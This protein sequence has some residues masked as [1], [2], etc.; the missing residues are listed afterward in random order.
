MMLNAAASRD[1]AVFP[2]R[3]SSDAYGDWLR[4]RAG[5]RAESPSDSLHRATRYGIAARLSLAQAIAK[6]DR[7]SLV[8]KARNVVL[9]GQLLSI[10]AP[11]EVICGFVASF[12]D[13]SIL[14][15]LGRDVRGKQ[16]QSRVLCEAG[17]S[18]SGPCAGDRACF[19][20]SR[21]MF[22]QSFHLLMIDGSNY[23]ETNA[24]D[25]PRHP[26]QVGRR[27]RAASPALNVRQRRDK[28]AHEECSKRRTARQIRNS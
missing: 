21:E 12:G 7:R 28:S 6:K 10:R 18:V 13:F 11:F 16:V 25:D 15:R 2:H 5:C 3:S 23:V 14:E 8:Y 9:A 27:A 22:R 19:W 4:A 17:L 1:I 24:N 26:K 20:A